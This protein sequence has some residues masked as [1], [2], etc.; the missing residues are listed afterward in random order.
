M[1]NG[2]HKTDIEEARL[3]CEA[4]ETQ[5]GKESVEA[6]KAWKAYALVLRENNRLL[7]AVNAEAKYKAIG[8]KLNPTTSQ[9]PDVLT[10]LRADLNKP[11]T[12]EDVRRTT[13]GLMQLAQTLAGDMLKGLA[14]NP[15]AIIGA[16]ILIAGLTISGYFWLC[17]DPSVDATHW[18]HTIDY[19]LGDE[20]SFHRAGD[21]YI[22]HPTESGRK[23]D[24][25]LIS[26]GYVEVKRINNVGLMADRQNG[27]Q[28][29]L[30]AAIIGAILLASGLK[31]K[32]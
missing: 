24:N 8:R 19:P 30:G 22:L 10:Q 16:L 11:I 32:N 7:D 21:P 15:L 1:I 13:E 14:V 4:A 26:M 20:G 18:T 31:R 28:I 27:I 23:F 3:K 29:G 9:N 25:R 2:E 6:L 12:A 5:F 17:F